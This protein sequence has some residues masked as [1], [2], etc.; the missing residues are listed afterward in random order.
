MTYQ[1]NKTLP[2]YREYFRH[3]RKCGLTTRMYRKHGWVWRREQ[4]GKPAIGSRDRGR[5]MRY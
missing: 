4:V 3:A 2:A 5:S 1:W